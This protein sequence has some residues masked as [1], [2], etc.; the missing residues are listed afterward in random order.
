MRI[1][2]L[3]HQCIVEP[4]VALA[5]AFWLNVYDGKKRGKKGHT[6]N[7][8]VSTLPW[9]E[10]PSWSW[11]DD[12]IPSELSPSNL[13]KGFDWIFFSFFFCPSATLLLPSHLSLF[14]TFRLLRT[15]LYIKGESVRGIHTGRYWKQEELHSLSSF[16]PMVAFL[17]KFV[18]SSEPDGEVQRCHQRLKETRTLPLFLAHNFFFFMV[19]KFKN[20]PKERASGRVWTIA[21]LLYGPEKRGIPI[22]FRS[23]LTRQ[24]SLLQ[25]SLCLWDHNQKHYRASA[26][27][28]YHWTEWPV[29]FEADS[30]LNK[31]VGIAVSVIL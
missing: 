16:L 13:V 6:N 11:D 18:V 30:L 26:W 21:L 14:S 5:K 28:F 12:I 8:V 24:N 15:F 10:T 4:V 25:K 17:H 22:D 1:L 2:P 29:Y 20:S 23:E 9:F 3:N 31:L 19:A 7:P 27:H